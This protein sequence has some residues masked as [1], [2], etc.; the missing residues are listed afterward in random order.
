[1]DPKLHLKNES[2]TFVQRVVS[3]PRWQLEDELMCQVLGFTLHGYLFGLGRI[4]CFMD[5]E[6]IHDVA[7]ELLAG[8]GMGRKY[9]EG[10]IEA[11]HEEFLRENNGSWQN[12]LN[13]VGHSHA[14]KEDLNVLA[15]S[16]F[17]NTALIKKTRAAQAKKPFWKFW[18]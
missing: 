11:A 1:M 5:V 12:Q 8:I 15:E 14:L 9:V 16:I 4:H 2:E 17:T 18:I 6:E 13:G 3:D 10:M 7:I